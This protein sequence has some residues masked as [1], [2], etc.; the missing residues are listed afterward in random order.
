MGKN[1]LGTMGLA[2]T[3]E[4]KTRPKK[5][6]H[7]WVNYQPCRLDN[8][9]GGKQ[10]ASL[11]MELISPFLNDYL[12]TNYRRIGVSS[13]PHIPFGG[14]THPP[15]PAFEASGGNILSLKQTST[16]AGCGMARANLPI[17]RRSEPVE[18]H[19]PDQGN[20]KN[21]GWERSLNFNMR[22][23]FVEQRKG[24]AC[25]T[26]IGGGSSPR[27]KTYDSS[28]LKTPV[29]IESVAHERDDTRKT[30][31]GARWLRSVRMVVLLHLRIYGTLQTFKVFLLFPTK[32]RLFVTIRPLDLGLCFV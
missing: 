26:Y 32:L 20:Q 22:A 31:R 2:E 1:C 21:N 12:C 19:L 29:N 4:E 7:L 25:T 24:V 13:L 9:V 28:A 30:R 3:W 16:I 5:K 15:S 23:L 6:K 8:W 17:W 10:E 14:R 27:P 18:T 11:H